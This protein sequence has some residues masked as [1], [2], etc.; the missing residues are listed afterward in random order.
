VAWDCRRGPGIEVIGASLFRPSSTNIGWMRSERS[1]LTSLTSSR[2]SGVLL[3]RRILSAGKLTCPIHLRISV[4]PP[5]A[6]CCRLFLRLH[7]GLRLVGPGACA[8][9]RG[10]Y[11]RVL[12]AGVR[13]VLVW[14]ELCLVLLSESCRLF[15]IDSY[16]LVY[17]LPV[18]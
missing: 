14:I 9:A 5:S 4:R 16:T 3:S 10:S 18:C 11:S 13:I 15:D 17:L 6:V 1:S 12:P 2:M 8:R 7:E